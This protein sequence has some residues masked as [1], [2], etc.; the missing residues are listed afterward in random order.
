MDERHG[1][2][3]RPNAMRSKKEESTD[4]LG[5]EEHFRLEWLWPNGPSNKI[6]D[7]IGRDPATSHSRRT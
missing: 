6:R 7:L 1:A 5:L 2:R 4:T 3:I